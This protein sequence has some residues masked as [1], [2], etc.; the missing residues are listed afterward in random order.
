[1]NLESAIFEVESRWALGAAR[2]LG[3]DS[4]SIGANEEY[5]WGWVFRFVP[6][7]G[8]SKHSECLCAFNKTTK[9]IAPVGTKGLQF[10]ISLISE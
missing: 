10:A 1:M 4:A 3:C 8:D 2:Y 5:E 9:K 6:S 7:N